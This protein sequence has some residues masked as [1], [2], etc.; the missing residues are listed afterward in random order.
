MASNVSGRVLIPACVY[1]AEVQYTREHP[2]ALRLDERQL[3]DCRRGS[4]SPCEADVR[5]RLSLGRAFRSW[6]HS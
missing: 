1:L 4:L 2:C 3:P 6:C 5:S